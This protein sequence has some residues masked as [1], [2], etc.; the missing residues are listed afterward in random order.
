MFTGDEEGASV[1]D[2]T[3]KVAGLDHGIGDS[4]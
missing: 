1:V 2:V 3:Q 4:V